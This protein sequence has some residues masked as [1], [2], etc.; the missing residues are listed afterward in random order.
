[1][2]K[3]VTLQ[4]AAGLAVFLAIPSLAS[5]L[6]I[7]DYTSAQNDRFVSGTYPS[8]PQPNTSSSFVGAA[9]DWSGVGWSDSNPT[10]SF[11]LLGSQFFLYANH[12]TPAVGSKIDFTSYNAASNSYTVHSYT[13][14][15]TSGQLITNADLAIG[16]F[17]S[18]IS[19]SDNVDS[20]YPILFL[21]YDTSASSPYRSTQYQNL[22][23]YGWTAVVGS[24]QF[25]TI[26]K[27]S[28]DSGYYYSYLF[29]ST[30]A[31]RAQ[32]ESGDSG[33]P[34]FITAN[35][36]M[37]LAGDHYAIVS[38]TDGSTGGV[39]SFLA[40]ELSYINNYM[41]QYGYLPYVA[42]PPTATWAGG[43]STSW[44]AATNWSTS[45]VPKDAFSGG[46]VKTCASVLFDASATSQRTINLDG[47]QVVTGI[48]FNSVSGANGFTIAAGTPTGSTLS[49]GEAGITNNDNDVQIFTCNI[50]L[51]SPQRWSIGT[52]GLVV[53][54]TIDTLDP[55]AASGDLLLVEGDGNATLAGQIFDSGALAKDGSGTLT[56]SANNSYSGQT[57]IHNGLLQVGGG[58]AAGTLGTGEV[59][60]NATL[61]FYR[62]GTIIVSNVISG[63]GNVQQKGPGT[64]VLSGTN[65]YSGTTTV[66]AG[67]L[68]LANPLALGTTAAGTIVQNGGALDLNGL[69]IGNET[70][71]IYGAGAGSGALVNT[72]TSAAAALSGPVTLGANAAAGGSG[73]LTLSGTVNYGT[74]AFTKTGA[75]TLTFTNSII[76]GGNSSVTVQTGALSYQLASGASAS[77]ASSI[78]TLHIDSGA[79]VSVNAANSDP[80]TDSTATTQ[81]VQI[82]NDAGGTFSLTAGTASIAGISGGGSTTLQAGT[83]LYANYVYQSTITLAPGATLTINAISGGPTASYAS[84]LLDSDLATPLSASS[85]RVVPEPSSWIL[86]LIAALCLLCRR[87]ILLRPGGRCT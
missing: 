80:F 13:V 30:T 85:L 29:D 22:L 38:Y 67:V 81:H 4:A 83:S 11:A 53:T 41:A 6:I 27:F 26:T 10:Q 57:F 70:I 15:S 21:G 9:Y 14:Q 50:V 39:D 60:N 48:T 64:L 62:S 84:A 56:L 74:Y 87:P 20:K 61:A 79:A 5:A 1:M 45:T 32:L 51:R 71:T 23:L 40:L 52:G 63:S 42:T 65:S 46:K 37:Y 7:N 78:P 73:N 44:A 49:I 17:T 25:N 66:S 82:I 16:M 55:Y 69:S 58:G 54:G 34:T 68:Q 47:N 35:G 28:G 36:Q 59:T 76:W 18:P 8:D 31:G 19:S 43:T 77:V 75:G 72:N 33:S 3:S 12:Y 2:W 86:F 24:N